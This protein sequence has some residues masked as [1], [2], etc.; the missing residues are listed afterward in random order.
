M[1]MIVFPTVL[2]C[3]D[4]ELGGGS[5][6]PPPGLGRDP[7]VVEGVGVQVLQ[8]VG[9]QGGV[10]QALVLREF[11]EIIMTNYNSPIQIFL[12]GQST[13][14]LIIPNLDEKKNPHEIDRTEDMNH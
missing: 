7:H 8:G 3:S 11:L 5:P 9:R 2:V 14:R 6:L 12:S 1:L 13:K 4:G 10:L